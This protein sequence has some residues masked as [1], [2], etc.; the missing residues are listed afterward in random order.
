LVLACSIYP[1]RIADVLVCSK[2]GQD[3]G[4]VKMRA[5]T[6]NS[7]VHV[8]GYCNSKLTALRRIYGTWPTETF[9]GFSAEEQRKFMNEVHG[10]SS[11]DLE[12]HYVEAATKVFKNKRER[13][14]K[15]EFQPLSYFRKLGYD[16][17]RIARET[18]PEDVE[19]HNQLG[20]TYRVRIRYTVDATEENKIREGI[21]NEVK[22]KLRDSAG[23]EKDKPQ[24][25]DRSSSVSSLSANSA[26]SDDSSMSSHA[27]KKK[28][29]WAGTLAKA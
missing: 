19:E 6:K 28:G 22:Q 3:G 1:E 14:Y 9:E 12:L 23:N 10:K 24:P 16:A 7:T 13:G 21:L 26:A 25:R 8:C 18:A 27:K 11:K 20:T 29:S 4:A 15:G 5:R 17:E 2:C